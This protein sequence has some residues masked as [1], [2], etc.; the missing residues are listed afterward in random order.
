MRA[1][2][3]R[4]SNA[5]RLIDKHLLRTARMRNTRT[6]LNASNANVVSCDEVFVLLAVES[7]FFKVSVSA[8]ASAREEL[9]TCIVIRNM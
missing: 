6:P 5:T 4:T 1:N 7:F 9:N 8:S 3:F 2:I